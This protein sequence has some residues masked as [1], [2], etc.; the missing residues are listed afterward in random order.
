MMHCTK[1]EVF[2]LRISLVNVTFNEEN[3][4]K[5]CIF[6]INVQVIKKWHI[7]YHKNKGSEK[8]SRWKDIHY[9]LE[10]AYWYGFRNL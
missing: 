4:E 1:N 6:Y 5:V 9:P 10:D 2:S 8:R 7:T 3:I